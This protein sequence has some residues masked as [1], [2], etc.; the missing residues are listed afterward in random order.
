MSAFGD[1]SEIIFHS[2]TE[3][4]YNPQDGITS[5]TATQ[6]RKYLPKGIS[7][8]H[9]RFLTCELLPKLGDILAGK[10][11]SDN[12]LGNKLQESTQLMNSPVVKFTGNLS[13]TQWYSVHPN[14]TDDCAILNVSSFGIM[15]FCTSMNEVPHRVWVCTRYPVRPGQHL[16]WFRL[17]VWHIVSA[18]LFKFLPLLL[19]K[20]YTPICLLYFFPLL[21][22]K[23]YTTSSGTHSLLP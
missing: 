23:K 5:Q 22:Q 14:V 4:T 1:D 7:C 13:G 11:L 6:M 10:V 2:F 20:K 16:S 21:L 19:Q 17:C 18:H 9:F 8:M 12:Q 3:D 15:V